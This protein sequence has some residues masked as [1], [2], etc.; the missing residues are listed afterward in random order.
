MN[1]NYELKLKMF[2]RIIENKRAIIKIQH[3]DEDELNVEQKI[4]YL[5]ELFE[6]NKKIFLEKYYMYLKSDDCVLFNDYL[7]NDAYIIEYY[8][9]KIREP[10]SKKKC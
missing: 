3:R 5:N 9:N 4:K 10:E 8:L 6:K 7:M 1:D 2:N